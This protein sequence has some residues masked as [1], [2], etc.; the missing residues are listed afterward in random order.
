[1]P[2]VFSGTVLDQKGT[3]ILQAKIQITQGDVVYQGTGSD[4]KIRGSYTNDNGEFRI[5]IDEAVDPK[6]VTLTVTKDGREI[7]SIT[8]PAPTSKIIAA[9]LQISAEEGGELSLKG[10][11]KGGEYYFESLGGKGASGDPIRDEF[12]ANMKELEGL[13]KNSRE[14]N[15]PL[16]LIVTGSESQIPNTDN[17]PFLPDGKTKNPNY[18]KSLTE[19]KELAKRR[20]EYLNERITKDLFLSE[21]G[22]WASFYIPKISYQI[23]GPTYPGNADYTQ[24]QYVSVSAKPTK[25][26]CKT[27]YVSPTV[28]GELKNIPYIASNAKYISFIAFQIPD[29]FGFNNYL[30]PYYIYND[31]NHKDETGVK[32]WSLF[33]YIFLY[34]SNNKSTAF[35][36]VTTPGLKLNYTILENKKRYLLDSTQGAV[37]VYNETSLLYYTEKL[38]KALVPFPQNRPPDENNY[39]TNGPLVEAFDKLLTDYPNEFTLPTLGE[40]NTITQ[41]PVTVNDTYGR[42]MAAIDEFFIRL[43]K[44]NVTIAGISVLSKQ[45]SIID[46]TKPEY[47]LTPNGKNN[48]AIAISSHPQRLRSQWAYCV[49]DKPFTNWPTGGGGVG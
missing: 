48:T 40:G 23:N 49:C 21:N 27:T 33:I 1:M 35:L 16:E 42:K 43:S 14:Q 24:Y 37:N 31:A 6:K 34:L 3:P 19:E 30:E 17:E 5:Q 13:I 28:A 32:S 8:N 4:P 22:K 44:S 11:Y 20:V 36:D 29:R 45:E 26:L 39:F 47:G 7:R 38:K 12:D 10:K 9:S 2:T 15:I 18:T 46:I 25:C 41:V